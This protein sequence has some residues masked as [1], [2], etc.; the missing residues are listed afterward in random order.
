MS[1]RALKGRSNLLFSGKILPQ[2]FLRLKE[3]A[4]SWRYSATP[5]NDILFDLRGLHIFREV[6]ELLRDF[7]ADASLR[8]FGSSADVR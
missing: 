5:R 1:L 7:R 8:F 4:L 3:I 2:N 6:D